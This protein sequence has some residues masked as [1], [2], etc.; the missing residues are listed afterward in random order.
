MFIVDFSGYIASPD[1]VGIAQPDFITVRFIYLFFEYIIKRWI[2]PNL[3]M[4]KNRN[5]IQ[6]WNIGVL[7]C[8]EL[9]KKTS[10]FF[11]KVFV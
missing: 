1:I 3:K 4:N 5:F 7:I 2:N 8:R 6:I 10:H 9:I 11:K